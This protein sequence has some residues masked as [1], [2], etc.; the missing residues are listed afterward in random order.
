M[1]VMILSRNSAAHVVDFCVI[2]FHID[3][4]DTVGLRLLRNERSQAVPFFL[5]NVIIFVNTECFLSFKVL[6]VI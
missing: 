1:R 4:K 6:P 3:L 2:C 5:H